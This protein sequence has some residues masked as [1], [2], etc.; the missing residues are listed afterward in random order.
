MDRKRCNAQLRGKP[1]Q[2]C[3]KWCLANG[4]CRLHGGKSLGGIA[5]PLFK[6]GKRSKYVGHLPKTLSSYFNEAM[7]DKDLTELREELALQSAMIAEAAEKMNETEAP[8]WGQVV[9]LLNDCKMAQRK[10]DQEKFEAAFAEMETLIRTGADAAH[11]QEKLRVKMRELMQE[12]TKTATAEWNRLHDMQGLV[13]L[14]TM[15]SWSRAVYEGIRAEI[16]E[17][18]QL[19]A[20]MS[21]I[22]QFMP[23]PSDNVRCV[24]QVEEHSLVQ[25][26]EPGEPE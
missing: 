23:A 11:N 6:H 13:K 22:M 19:R 9:E 4:R 26:S 20:V 3:R 2:F 24:E 15:M 8:P 17:P 18:V 16:H 10:K 1:G 5:S 12:R 21:R 14:D 25:R 7:D